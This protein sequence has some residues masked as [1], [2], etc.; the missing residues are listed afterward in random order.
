MHR[1]TSAVWGG[2]HRLHCSA[3]GRR[4]AEHSLQLQL[5]WLQGQAAGWALPS[6]PWL[7]EPGSAFT[8]WLCLCCAFHRSSHPLSLQWEQAECGTPLPAPGSPTPW[9]CSP[10]L[11]V[12]PTAPSPLCQAGEVLPA[13]PRSQGTVCRCHPS[14]LPLRLALGE[15]QPL[16]WAKVPVCAACSAQADPAS[17]GWQEGT[18]ESFF[19]Y[20][21]VGGEEK[22]PGFLC[23]MK[24]QRQWAIQKSSISKELGALT[25]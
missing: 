18:R 16:E 7:E 4:A 21:G 2:E 10:R 25:D 11:C 17:G 1:D 23:Q 12:P 19:V 24:Y 15:Q 3:Q 13:L 5:A 8:L 14:F 22:P 20:T 6:P 9:W